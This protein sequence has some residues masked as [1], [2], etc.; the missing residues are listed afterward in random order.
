MPTDLIDIVC[1]RCGHEF[2]VPATL[3]GGVSNCPG[4][5]KLVEIKGSPDAA[6]YWILVTMGVLVIIGLTVG[7]YAVGGWLPALLCFLVGAG[8]M[9]V[10]VLAS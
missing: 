4:C 7:C 2:E 10:I 5:H 1:P 9:A 6:I 3:Q 8:I